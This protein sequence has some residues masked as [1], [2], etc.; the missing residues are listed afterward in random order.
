MFSCKEC[1]R[2][3]C[4][5]SPNEVWNKKVLNFNFVADSMRFRSGLWRPIDEHL[6]KH[7]QHMNWISHQH[8]DK[9]FINRVILK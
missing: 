8:F 7:N 1:N 5:E 9:R 3:I 2:L 6:D 4:V